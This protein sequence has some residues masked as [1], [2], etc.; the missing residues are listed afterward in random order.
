[1]TLNIYLSGE[2]HTDWRDQII[3]GAK[4][5]DVQFNSP[6]TDHGASDDCGVAILGAEPNKFWHDHKGAKINAIRTR[7]GIEEAD[8]VVVRF[9]EKY[10][11]W[12]AAFDAGYAAALGKSLIVL[13]QDEHQHALKEVHAAA[14]A[15]AKEPMQVVEI[16]RYVLKGSLPA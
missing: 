4:D 12:N 14:L 5:L 10:K 8:I 2:I 7:K 15:V 13:S 16:L 6:V 9:G 1:M 11:Q 3:N